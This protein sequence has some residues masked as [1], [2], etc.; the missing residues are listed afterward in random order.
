MNASRT[1]LARGLFAPLGP[2]YDR[3][4]NLLS[5]GQDPRWRRFLVARL[6]VR[7]DDTVLDVACGTAAVTLELV[8]Q[9]G[10]AVVGVDPRDEEAPPARVLAERE[11]VRVAVVGRPERREQPARDPGPGLCHAVSL[12]S[13]LGAQPAGSVAWR[14]CARSSRRSPREAVM[15]SPLLPTTRTRGSIRG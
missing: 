3:Y 10:C 4:A 14:R 15:L 13:L 6:P 9:K 11:E 7:P 12:S 2:S 8:R 1:D 5:F